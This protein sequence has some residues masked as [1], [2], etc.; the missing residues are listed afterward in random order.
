MPALRDGG[1][2]PYLYGIDLGI[3]RN[4]A[5]VIYRAADP[6]M[7]WDADCELFLYD[8]DRHAARGHR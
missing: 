6:W 3:Q 1:I 4:T 8:A 5:A 7:S 2:L